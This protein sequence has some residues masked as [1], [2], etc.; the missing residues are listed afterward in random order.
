METPPTGEIPEYEFLDVILPPLTRVTQRP[1]AAVGKKRH[2][3][4]TETLRRRRGSLRQA[5]LTVDA[6]VKT[7]KKMGPETNGRAHLAATVVC[8]L[9]RPR[10]HLKGEEEHSSGSNGAAMSLGGSPEQNSTDGAVPWVEEQIPQWLRAQMAA[11]LSPRYTLTALARRTRHALGC[12]SQL[13]LFPPTLPANHHAILYE[14][15]LDTTNRVFP[16][17]AEWPTR[18]TRSLNL[19]QQRLTLRVR[20]LHGKASHK[21]YLNSPCNR[22]L[23]TAACVQ[24]MRRSRSCPHDGARLHGRRAVG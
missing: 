10:F 5:A 24:M 20:S 17:L 7:V 21:E 22:R 15:S 14:L 1:N 23:T 2:P 4:L 3:E 16:R 11:D 9:H 8:S 13:T 6:Q 19:K 18:W 12:F